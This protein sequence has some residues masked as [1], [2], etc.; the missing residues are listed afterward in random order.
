MGKPNL[1][2]VF[3]DSFIVNGHTFHIEHKE[4]ALIFARSEAVLLKNSVSIKMKNAIT[5]EQHMGFIHPDGHYS[6]YSM[7]EEAR[8]LTDGEYEAPKAG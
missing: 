5:G 2:E 4:R 7:D 6:H 8:G 1:S 3:N